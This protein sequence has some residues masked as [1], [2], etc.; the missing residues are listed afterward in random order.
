MERAD[1]EAEYDVTVA[2]IQATLQFANDLIN[3]E[4]FHAL[5]RVA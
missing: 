1:I 3:Q 4:S 2:D 5:P